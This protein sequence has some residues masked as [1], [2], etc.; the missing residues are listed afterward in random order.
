MLL[1]AEITVQNNAMHFSGA[2]YQPFGFKKWT[3]QEKKIPA[4]RWNTEFL[5][6]TRISNTVKC[7][8]NQEVLTWALY[9]NVFML[10]RFKFH[11]EWR[12]FYYSRNYITGIYENIHI[13]FLTCIFYSTH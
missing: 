4:I 9:L 7:Y 5:K 3:V 6:F 13:Y 8:V 11:L 2:T 10:W 12:P 1:Q